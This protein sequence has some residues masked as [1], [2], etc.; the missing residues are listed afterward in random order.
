MARSHKL[1]GPAT[2]HKMWR[3]WLTVYQPSI[4]HSEKNL[5][6]YFS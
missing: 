3:M 4:V 1:E 5:N 6:V 2:D